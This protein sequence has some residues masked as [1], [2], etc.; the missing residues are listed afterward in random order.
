MEPMHAQ[1]FDSTKIKETDKTLLKLLSR[2]RQDLAEER[3]GSEVEI[4]F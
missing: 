2:R 3:A 1:S 4:P